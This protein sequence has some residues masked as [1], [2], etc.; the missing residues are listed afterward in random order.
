[1]NRV[2]SFI[3]TPFAFL[4]CV[5]L[6]APTTATAQAPPGPAS[7]SAVP[8]K[9]IDPVTYRDVVKRVLPAVVSIEPQAARPSARAAAKQ[10]QDEWP[11]DLLR[12]FGFPDVATG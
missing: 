5:L 6:A 12:R 9:A 4:V 3:S 2:P 8:A 11:G 10:L 1:M 7:A